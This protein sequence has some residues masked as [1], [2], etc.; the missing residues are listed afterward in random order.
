MKRKE[1]QQLSDDD[2]FAKCSDPEA[3]NVLLARY[4]PGLYRFFA[5]KVPAVDAE[6]LTQK[7]LTVLMLAPERGEGD[8][9]ES[10]RSFAFGAARMVLL[11]YC[12]RRAKGVQFDPVTQS[13][14][15][16]DPSL[17]K[18]IS[19]RN[20]LMWLSSAIEALPV[21]TQILLDLRYGEHLT[22]REISLIYKI[23]EPTL[24]RRMQLLKEQLLEMRKDFEKK[25][26]Q[27]RKMKS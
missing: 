22:Y 12:S 7:L 2:L 21:E 24:R 9:V 16:L 15:A 11:N 26:Q 25:K 27:Q 5:R 18:Q 14:M 17:S 4:R 19:E 20:R 10:F 3:A 23:P 1:L 6:D 13:L 8:K